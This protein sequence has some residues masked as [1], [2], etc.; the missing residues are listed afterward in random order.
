MLIILAVLV[1]F[2][3]VTVLL[4]Y[5]TEKKLRH[6]QGIFRLSLGVAD[7]MTGLILF[8]V[9]ANS[10]WKTYQGNFEFLPPVNVSEE[11]FFSNENVIYLN[12][13]GSINSLESRI[14]FV[15]RLFPGTFLDSI[16]FFTTLS[17]TVSIYLLTVS[18]IDRLQ[19]ITRPI[20]YRQHTAKRFAIVCSVFCWVLAIIVS[21]LPIFVNGIYYILT[22]S[23]L[24]TLTGLYSLILY[25]VGFFIPLLATWIISIAMFVQGKKSYRRRASMSTVRQK[26]INQQRKLNFI[27][28]LM[29]IAFSLSIFPTILVL[30]LV[31]FIPGTDPAYLESYNP[32][33]N[34]LTNSLETTA[35][36]VLMSN[37]LWNC[38]IYSLRTKTFRKTA[39]KK[40]KSIWRAISPFNLWKLLKRYSNNHKHHSFSQRGISRSFSSSVKTNTTRLESGMPGSHSDDMKVS[41]IA[42]KKFRYRN[43]SVVKE[44]STTSN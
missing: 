24:V 21:A 34:N 7:L 31:L 40:Y 20:Q 37:S 43:P 25:T 9:A 3:N 33:F 12:T 16:G 32:L 18:G 26:H 29:V 17:L 42:P 2:A 4:V 30:I 39:I 23:G 6:S 19:A 10:L 11:L 28:S 27:L 22:G 8:P 36:I 1:V 5:L 14:S 13:S 44:R 38:L 41:P 15:R 35:V